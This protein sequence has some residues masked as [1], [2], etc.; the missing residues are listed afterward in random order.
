M[1]KRRRRPQVKIKVTTEWMST[2]E[3][4]AYLR[5]PGVRSLYRLVEGGKLP[6]YRLGKRALIF[7]K[8]ELDDHIRSNRV[9]PSPPRKRRPKPS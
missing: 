8:S 6:A 7:A 2:E 4:L 5:L 3:A 1:K 9:V